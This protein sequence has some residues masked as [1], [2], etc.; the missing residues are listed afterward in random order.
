MRFKPG[1]RWKTRSSEIRYKKWRKSVFELNKGKIGSSKYYMCVKCNKRRKTT[2]VL[3]AHH[4]FSWDKFKDKRY[5]FKNAVVLCRQCHNQFH[6][7]YKFEALEKPEL[8]VDW[9][10]NKNK[11]IIKEYIKNEIK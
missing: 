6:H 2:R 4:I 3:H 5:D 11:N 8:L 1:N 7:K 10:G 9:L